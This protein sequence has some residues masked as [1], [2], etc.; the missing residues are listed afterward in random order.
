MSLRFHP[1][2]G[3]FFLSEP[4]RPT[5]HAR[6]VANEFKKPTDR[7]RP[8]DGT[9]AAD[10]YGT[11]RP[12]DEM[13][14]PESDGRTGRFRSSDLVPAAG[15]AGN[16]RRE[17]ASE[18]REAP[19]VAVGERPRSDHRRRNGSPTDR[20]VN[21]GGSSRSEKR[22]RP[23]SVWSIHIEPG[24]NLNWSAICDPRSSCS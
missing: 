24:P 1:F 20:A 11:R 6:M 9:T 8:T 5:P 17:R 7:P 18:R 15:G 14:E 3:T 10:S 12:P 4:V 22:K 13:I 19:P 21:V 23:G 2:S 16:R